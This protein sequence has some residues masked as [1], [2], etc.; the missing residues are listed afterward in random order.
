M[1]DAEIPFIADK[2]LGHIL[3]AMGYSPLGQH[4]L[5]CSK[6]RGSV[7]S[8]IP[9]HFMRLGKVAPDLIRLYFE[10]FSDL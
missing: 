10:Q 6:A 8:N 3:Q 7:W 5:N 2:T 1:A 4:R 9:K